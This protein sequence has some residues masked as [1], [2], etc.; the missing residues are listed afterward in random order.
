MLIYII[1][2][3]IFIF[4]AIKY[5]RNSNSVRRKESLIFEFL[6]L[7]LV[8]GFRNKLGGDTYG[9]MDGWKY[10]PSISNIFN[11]GISF[12]N[13]RYSAL[14]VLLSSICRSIIDSFYF[15]Q[16]IHAI[17]VNGVFLWFFNKYSK[18]PFTCV[19]V[20]AIFFFFNYNTE[21]LRAAIAVAVFL[22]SY[23]YLE[24]KKLI[25]YYICCFVAIGFHTEAVITLIF[26]LSLLIKEY[27]KPL[28]SVST[29]IAISIILMLSIDLTAFELIQ[30][31]QYGTLEEF[32]YTEK[33]ELNL[34]GTIAYSFKVIPFIMLF[35][36]KKDG[37]RFYYLLSIFLL[38]MTYRYTVM[39]S[40]MMDFIYPLAII[41]FS[42]ILNELRTLKIRYHLK[43]IALIWIILL[44]FSYSWSM[45]YFGDLNG[46][47]SRRE[48]YKLY[49]PY[50][51]W[52]FDEENQERNQFVK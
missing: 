47:L 34:N 24:A 3:L 35:L 45:F 13:E 42:D 16:F 14:W 2:L 11:Y 4:N 9:Y 27:K 5:D 44:Q 15:F 28:L 25:K 22:F 6:L 52:L 12:T 36:L 1:V 8:A 39:F 19:V 29:V 26:P 31:I 46:R 23:K 33:A 43:R 18:N 49:F 32:L 50:T 48:S 37:F 7:V 30:Q 10:Y 17:I 38:T 41:S 21:I 40:R 51:S 20:Y